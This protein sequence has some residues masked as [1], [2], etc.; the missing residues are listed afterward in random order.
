MN[1]ISAQKLVGVAFNRFFHFRMTRLPTDGSPHLQ[2]FDLF[3]DVDDDEACL[4][5]HRSTP[6]ALLMFRDADVVCVFSSAF[7]HPAILSLPSGQSLPFV[8]FREK[9]PAVDVLIDAFVHPADVLI[10]SAL[11]F[12]LRLA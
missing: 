4:F 1:V 7:R 6:L 8:Q 9:R 3:D 11:R 12:A 5:V 10:A 2:I